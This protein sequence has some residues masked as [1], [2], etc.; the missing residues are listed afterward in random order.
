MFN[1]SF[2]TGIFPDQLKIAKVI[3]LFKSDDKRIINN[4]RPISVLPVF[5][6]IIEK[7]MHKRLKNFLDKNG[8]LTHSQFGFR[9]GLST[10]LAIINMV[11]KVTEAIDNKNEC[12]GVFL[13]LSKA[14]DTI[15]HDILLQKLNLL[16]I[17]GVVN[18]WFRS[19]LS[20]RQ[21]FVEISHERSAL[22]RISCGVPQGSIL[23]PLLF[24]V[25]I[26]DLVNAVKDCNIIMFADDTNLFFSN[27]NLN[28]LEKTINRELKNI[29]LWFNLNK[30]SLNVKKTNFILFGYSKRK[31]PLHI[32]IN[33][34]KIDQTDKTKFLGVIINQTVTWSDH[35][36]VVTHKVNKSIGILSRLSRTIPSSV[37]VSLY[38]S[39]VAPYYDYCNIA[40]AINNSVML[41]KVYKTQK[42]AV[43]IIT[44]SSFNSH[45]KPLFI[46][47]NILPLMS[48]NKL[49]VGC[50]MF[51]A[52]HSLLPNYFNSMFVLNSDVHSHF[53]RHQSDLHL[54]ASRLN[55]RK[56]S[57][58]VFGPT[59]WNSVPSH[60][61]ASE[62]LHQ[63]SNSFKCYLFTSI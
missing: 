54:N 17:R 63:F 58:K 27:K 9:R 53:T 25:Y 59:L 30:L 47:L 57:L 18:N 11:D 49:R 31:K 36:N 41:D 8:I 13:D 62:S 26:N 5:S 6:K 4:Y 28:D 40:W 10:E 3:P 23:G 50:F 16:G 61:K 29:C 14:F 20:N 39:L 15:D 46:K 38:Q 12:V 19:Y 24:I 33:D 2:E 34:I 32:C 42:R 7:L 51:R 55:I 21:Q 56:F 43:R 52:L 48:L 35:I 45:T 44:N 22:M 1:L 60:I 37:L